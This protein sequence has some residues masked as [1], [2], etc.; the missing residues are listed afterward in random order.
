MASI[1][2]FLGLDSSPFEA[3]LNRARAKVAA[4]G[5]TLTKTLQPGKLGSQLAGAFTIGAIGA[6][7]NKVIDF[8]GEIDDTSKRLGISTDAVQ[9]FDFALKQSGSSL[10]ENEALF[11]KLRKAVQAAA[12][13]D[14]KLVGIFNRFGVS[15]DALKS[16]NVDNIFLTISDSIKEAGLSNK[17][18]TDLTEIMG[19]TAANVLPAMAS[20]FRSVSDEAKQLGLVLDRDAIARLDELGD[21]RDRAFLGLSVSGGAAVGKFTKAIESLGV[22][23]ADV[24][25]TLKD[26]FTFKTVPQFLG[27]LSAIGLEGAPVDEGLIRE[28]AKQKIARDAAEEAQAMA[29]KQSAVLELQEKNEKSLAELAFDRLST[30]EK[31]LRITA[32]RVALMERLKSIQDPLRQQ[33]FISAELAASKDLESL[34]GK[35]RAVNIKPDLNSL[36]QVG[37][38]TAQRAINIRPEQIAQKQ[39]DTLGK[40]EQNTRQTKGK[41]ITFP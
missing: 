26:L 30:E 38:F 16:K 7:I 8:G 25:F 32:F 10:R 27:N 23:S 20:G 34:A 35:Q 5:T 24:K 4:F 29:E 3:G 22:A 1:K 13:G 17:T 19:K 41:T 40:I 33:Q 28:K 12:D 31:I 37:A 11:V 9:S 14:T 15:V 2:A 39:L 21:A 18:F 36:Q 6:S